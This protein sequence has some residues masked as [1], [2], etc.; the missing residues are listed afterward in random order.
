MGAMSFDDQYELE[1]LPAG[2]R[3]P[4]LVAHE[5]QSGEKCLAHFFTNPAESAA[6]AAS[7][8]RLAERERQRI[9]SR[10]EHGGLSYVV[11]GALTG[12]AGIREWLAANAPERKP[13]DAVGA[14]KV[15]LPERSIDEQ[16]L[17][18][19]EGGEGTQSKLPAGLGEAVPADAPRRRAPS[20]SIQ[21]KISRPG[22]SRRRI[23]RRRISPASSHG[24]SRPRR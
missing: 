13:L 18:L 22:I 11:T 4:H 23:S 8:D 24:C 7:V 9:A 19:F 17:N 2:R 15:I 12:Y 3:Y 5:K 6:L 16:F 14:W 10:G 20:H 1:W 21:L